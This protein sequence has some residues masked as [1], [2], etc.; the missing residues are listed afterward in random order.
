MRVHSRREVD[1]APGWTRLPNA[2]EPARQARLL[3]RARNHTPRGSH[4]HARAHGSFLNQVFEHRRSS[5]N[6]K[7]VV[8]RVYPNS[9]A[10]GPNLRIL[11]V[12][13]PRAFVR[14]MARRRHLGR[15]RAERVDGAP[16]R[17]TVAS[18][19]RGSA[20][21]RASHARLGHDHA[22]PSAILQPVRR[23]ADGGCGAVN[24]TQI[25][26]ELVKSVA[27]RYGVSP[28]RCEFLRNRKGML[29]AQGR[30]TECDSCP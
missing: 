13:A 28:I 24:T 14:P 11:L 18:T 6:T 9:W 19:A 30:A 12:G 7:A 1:I 23:A 2:E 5:V 8:Y 21:A 3:W 20:R 26:G 27:Y 22:F 10:L 16:E 29:I 4:H 25:R 17:H 15:E